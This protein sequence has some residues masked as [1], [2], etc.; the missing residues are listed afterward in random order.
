MSVLDLLF[1]VAIL[2]L[3]SLLVFVFLVRVVVGLLFSFSSSSSLL[4]SLS[5]VVNIIIYHF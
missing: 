5:E 4:N 3:D 1:V 2:L